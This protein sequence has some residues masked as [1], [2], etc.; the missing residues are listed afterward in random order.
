VSRCLVDSSTLNN[1]RWCR[2][3][4]IFATTEAP[5]LVQKIVLAIPT[6]ILPP[7]LAGLAVNLAS[8]PDTVPAFA[9]PESLKQLVARVTKTKDPRVMKIVRGISEWTLHQQSDAAEA[10]F[11]DFEAGTPLP[12]WSQIH[13]SKGLLDPRKR[14]KNDVED[15]EPTIMDAYTYREE[16]LWAPVLRDIVKLLSHQSNDLLVEVL[17][18]LANLSPRDFPSHLGWADVV[19]MPGTC[20]KREDGCCCLCGDGEL[21]QRCETFWSAASPPGWQRM[22]CASRRF[23]SSPQPLLTRQRQM[24]WQKHG[25]CHYWQMCWKVRVRVSVCARVC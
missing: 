21:L 16:G 9:E 18:T 4:P 12:S 22:T 20:C 13:R 1:D 10:V 8:H 23:R 11:I 17:G 14:S 7:E 15:A 5:S 24:S 19:N 2:N 25:C 6:P 3:K